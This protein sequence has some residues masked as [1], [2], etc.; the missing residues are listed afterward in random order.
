MPATFISKVSF[1]NGPD[2][3][4]WHRWDQKS[5]FLKSSL[6]W[7]MW[8]KLNTYLLIILTWDIYVF[9]F[10][11][12]RPVQLVLFYFRIRRNVYRA[13]AGQSI[14]LFT[15]SCLRML[16]GASVYLLLV[17]VRIF[18]T[19]LSLA[20]KPHVILFKLMQFCVLTKRCVWWKIL[21]YGKDGKCQGSV[22]GTVARDFLPS[23]FIVNL[24]YWDPR[25]QAATILTSFVYSQRY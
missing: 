9:S 18:N 17:G 2:F 12:Y 6:Y 20:Q 16:Y 21:M 3:F 23:I 8:L 11:V 1:W 10:F 5:H 24:V 13:V 14:H 22:K 4:K 19:I 25:F 15:V 7:L